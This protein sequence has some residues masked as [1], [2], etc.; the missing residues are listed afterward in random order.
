MP[1]LTYPSIRQFIRNASYA[2]DHCLMGG[3]VIIVKHK[4]EYELRVKK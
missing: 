3:T 1:V 2:F 4:R